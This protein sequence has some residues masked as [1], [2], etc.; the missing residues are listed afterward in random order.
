MVALGVIRMAQVFCGKVSSMTTMIVK[1]KALGAKGKC[2]VI[3][4]MGGIFVVET[5]KNKKRRAEPTF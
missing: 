1:G 4:N 5:N 2:Y 3:V